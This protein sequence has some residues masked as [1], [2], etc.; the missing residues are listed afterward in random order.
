MKKFKKIKKQIKIREKD[1]W[2]DFA[3]PK[4]DL[5]LAFSIVLSVLIIYLSLPSKIFFFDGIMF[6]SESAGIPRA[7]ANHI[8]F[9]YCGHAFWKLLKYIGI[10]RD[11]YS[12][13]QTMNSFFGSLIVGLLFLFIKKVTEKNY[14]AIIF[15]LLFAFSHTFW[16]RVCDAYDTPPWIFWLLISIMLIWSYIKQT[17]KLK[18]IIF[19]IVV[20]IA[21]LAHQS[22]IFFI[23]TALCGIVLAG[24]K[25]FKNI[26]MFLLVISIVVG[27]PYILTLT[28][29]EKTLIDVS[30]GKFA[31]NN[32][33]IKASYKWMLGNAGSYDPEK[34]VNA[35]VSPLKLKELSFSKSIKNNLIDSN[36]RNLYLDFCNMVN[37][38][39]Y[40][41][42][43]K[44]FWPNISKI[45]FIII[46]IFL[47][48]KVKLWRNQKYKALVILTVAWWLTYMI[49]CSW[50]APG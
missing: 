3:F 11:G 50:F 19:S 36:L 41:R 17:S 7:W 37:A 27:V 29:Q 44:Q 15:S 14:I 21:V 39:W 9:C 4:K 40:G 25:V 2:Q 12:T 48:I 33:T 46:G 42:H 31:V 18:L 22:N 23:P 10:E 1:L 49:F 28:Y 45:I 34:Y 35:Y 6:A 26:L 38:M 13:L 8:S 47:F 32:K 5:L 43:S 16:W 20:G 30:T 24:K